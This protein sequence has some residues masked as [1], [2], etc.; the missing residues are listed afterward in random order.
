MEKNQIQKSK[1]HNHDNIRQFC[2]TK[3]LRD[4]H[5]SSRTNLH[6]DFTSSR[7]TH[8]DARFTFVYQ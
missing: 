5:F 4:S 7:Y 3:T 2:E 6:A 8:R 1:P